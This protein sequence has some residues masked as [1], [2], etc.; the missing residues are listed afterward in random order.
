MENL[1][2]T[3]EWD[4]TFPKSDKVDHE[5]VTF[6]NRYGITLAADVY[7]PKKVEG[8]LE[9]VVTCGPFGAVKEQAS[10]LYAQQFAERGFLA[11]AIDP[12]FTGESGGEPRLMASPDINTEDFCAAVDYLSCREDVD[13]EKIGLVGICGFGGFALNAMANDARIKATVASTMYDMCRTYGQGMFDSENTAIDRDKKCED[14]CRQRTEDYRNGYYRLR[15]TNPDVVPTEAPSFV[16]HYHDYYKTPRGFH[17]RSG[18]ST[19]GWTYTVQLPFINFTL[20]D[21]LGEVKKPVMLVHG[22]RAHSLYFAKTA[23][24]KMTGTNKEF[25]LVPNATHCDLYDQLDNIPFDRIAAFLH[26]NL[27]NPTESI[28]AAHVEDGVE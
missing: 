8:R 11:M 4:K 19:I 7:K 1:T 26:K 28:T 25:V 6:V 16:Q 13:S 9:A 3:Q 24:S 10:G 2:L 21:R 12:S 14:M 23:F 17:P 15:D 22:E 5:K 27:T 18:G 20:L